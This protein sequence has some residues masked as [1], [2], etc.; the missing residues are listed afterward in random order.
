MNINKALSYVAFGFLFTLVNLNL[1]FGTITVNVFPDFVGWILFFLAFDELG[2]YLEGKR[3]MKWIS[4]GMI[5]LT[6]VIWVMRMMSPELELNILTTAATIVSLVYMFILFGALEQVARDYQSKRESTIRMLKIV[7]LILYVAFVVTA[8]GF[9]AVQQAAWAMV[10][11]VVGA[12][13][14]VAAIITL[15]VLFQLRREIRERG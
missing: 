5:I 15:V 13:A 9:I 8:L 2:T 12:A 4:L 11:A 1:N 7:N 6:A 14:L 10:A 3:Y